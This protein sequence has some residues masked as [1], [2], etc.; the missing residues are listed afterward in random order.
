MHREEILQIS[1]RLSCLFSLGETVISKDRLQILKDMLQTEQAKVLVKRTLGDRWTE[2]VDM[3]G[4][5]QM[6]GGKNWILPI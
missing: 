3:N 2:A 4:R 5:F 1:T 6:Q